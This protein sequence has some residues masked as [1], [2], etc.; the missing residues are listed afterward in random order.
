MGGTKR[1][2]DKPHP[3]YEDGRLREPEIANKQ[4]ATYSEGKLLA[5]IKKAARKP[6]KR[7]G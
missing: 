6:A 7:A 5:L 4:D 1:N 2:G 3:S